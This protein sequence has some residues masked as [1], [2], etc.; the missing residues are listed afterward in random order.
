MIKRIAIG[1]DHAGFKLKNEIFEYLKSLNY[2]VIDC[3][4][5]SEE[6]CDYPDYSKVVAESIV[7]KKADAGILFCGTGIGVCI[8][9]NKI[10][11]IRAA[12][13]WNSETAKLAR[14]HNDANIICIGARFIASY[15]AKEI[16]NSYLNSEFQEGNHKRRVEKI[17]QFEK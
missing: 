16:I 11:G 12:T 8:A 9:A 10:K 4:T 5:Y 2:V 3:G 13:V 7:E 15:Y 1:S 17:I 6:S 14:Q